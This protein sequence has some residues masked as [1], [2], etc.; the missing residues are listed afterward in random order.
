[1]TF[2]KLM[3]LCAQG[4]IF[5]EDLFDPMCEHMTKVAELSKEEYAELKRVRTAT[6]V[7]CVFAL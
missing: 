3:L 7:D 6:L 4:G 5:A 2:H 1:M